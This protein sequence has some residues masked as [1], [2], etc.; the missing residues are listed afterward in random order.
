[1]RLSPK[2][3]PVTSDR[4]AAPVTSLKSF[5]RRSIPKLSVLSVNEIPMR[6][7]LRSYDV[8]RVEA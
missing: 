8:V 1:M 4:A 3:V 5:T 2:L 6:I 7:N